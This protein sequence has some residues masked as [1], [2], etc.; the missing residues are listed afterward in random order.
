MGYLLDTNVLSEIRKGRRADANVMRWWN[1]VEAADLY[2]SVLC[3]GEIRFGIELKRRK[4]SKQS[5]ILERWL[6]TTITQFGDRILLVTHSV[7]ERWGSMSLDERLPDT[8]GLMAA[9]ALVHGL[10]MV[11]RNTKD[12]RRSGASILNPWA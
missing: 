1:Q 10:T 5:E 6:E 11:T 7:A 4:D 2:V 3:L 9:T 12:F 8:D